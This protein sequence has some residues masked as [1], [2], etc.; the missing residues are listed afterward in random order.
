MDFLTNLNLVGYLDLNKNELRN[1]RVQNL[2]SAPSSP[3]A[4]QI[5]Y[6]TGVN[7]FYVYNGSGWVTFYPSTTTLDSIT[8]PTAAV[9][10][11]SQKITNLATPTVGTDATTKAYVDGV[12]NGV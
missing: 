5:Y 6:D 4:G 3:V 7:K 12:A 1:A 11:N 9:S 8:A 2:G 10:L